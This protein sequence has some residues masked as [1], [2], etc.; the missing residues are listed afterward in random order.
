MNLYQLWNL[1]K[2]PGGPGYWGTLVPDDNP[3]QAL[4]VI[5]EVCRTLASANTKRVRP[6]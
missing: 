5:R 1:N 4:S 3:R 6:R 2:S